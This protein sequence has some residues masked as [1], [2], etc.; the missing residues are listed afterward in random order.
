MLASDPRPLP[1]LLL[2]LSQGFHT[3]LV[4]IP[5]RLPYHPGLYF[6]AG[7]YP[8][9]VSI[10]CRLPSQPGL[11]SMQASI[12]A[13]SLF[14]AGFYPSLVS[15]PCRLLSQPGLY[16]MQASILAWSP[17]HTALSCAELYGMETHCILLSAD[18]PVETPQ[19][20]G[21]SLTNISLILRLPLQLCHM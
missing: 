12:P 16:S 5:C 2:A 14:H 1:Q 8:S 17:F 18:L 21:Q 19:H 9:L 13:W 11:Y 7:F 3:S 15:I 4:S 20:P 6:H 10:P